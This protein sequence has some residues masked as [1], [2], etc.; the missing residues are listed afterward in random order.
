M[1]FSD[2]SGPALRGDSIALEV[3]GLVHHEFEVVVAV[4]AHGHVIVVLSPLLNR[5]LAVLGVLHSVRVVLL[6]S[7]EELVQDFVLCLLT[8]DNIWVLLGVVSLANVVDV[9]GA[10]SVLVHDLKGLYGEA[11]SELVHLATHAT[12]ELL[13]VNGTIIRSIKYAEKALA[14]LRV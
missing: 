14:V 12:E 8:R 4:D 13:V 2:F 6:E 3:P 11:L 5:D 10:G 9:D 7:V 1:A